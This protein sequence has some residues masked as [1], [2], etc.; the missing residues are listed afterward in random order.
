MG[1]VVIQY[2]I[3]ITK[4]PRVNEIITL[5]TESKYYNKFFL[6]TVNFGLEIIKVMYVFT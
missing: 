5:E 4:M 1:W 2:S 3:D 6:H